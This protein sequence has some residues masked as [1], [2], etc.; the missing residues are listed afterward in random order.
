[1]SAEAVKPEGPR[2]LDAEQEIDL[3]RFWRAVLQR[4]WLVLVGVVVGAII[5][6]LVSLGGG[7]QYKATAEVYLGQPL[8]PGASQAISSI[9]TSLAL[10]SN[11]VTS[12]TAIRNAA[13]RAGLGPGQLR[14]HVSS[15]P[16]L[17]LTGTKLGTAAPL[18]NIT[19]TG[20][21]RPK[22]ARA[23]NALGRIAVQQFSGYA[24]SKLRTLQS[25]IDVA[26]QQLAQVNGRLK[27]ATDGLQQ[28]LGDNGLSPT[29]KLIAIANF[30]QVISTAS[31]QQNQLQNN[32]SAAQ[33][34]LAAAQ[35]VEQPRVV[36]PAAATRSAG[37]SRRSGVIVGA[38][39][40]FVLGVLAAVLWE[41]VA[42]RVRHAT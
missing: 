13:A 31:G 36:S 20:S 18:L 1:M 25:Q 12:E 2:D 39:I 19:V 14:G 35:A 33:Q 23:A 26:Q 38:I 30:N 21:S 24:A 7:K 29:D 8:N 32:L 15:R 42:T 6:L 34:Q 3:G 37:P 40:G 28:V 11:L 41:P 27:T 17:G 22:T 4:W 9:S 5:G 16:I 10:A